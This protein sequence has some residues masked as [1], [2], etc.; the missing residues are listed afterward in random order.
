MIAII[1]KMYANQMTNSDDDERQDNNENEEENHRQILEK[2]DSEE[3]HIVDIDELS[4]FNSSCPWLDREGEIRPEQSENEIEEMITNM[5]ELPGEIEQNEEMCPDRFQSQSESDE[6]QE[7]E[8]LDVMKAENIPVIIER[9]RENSVNSR[10]D[11]HLEY[12]A[13]FSRRIRRS[14]HC[15]LTNDRTAN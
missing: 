9:M 6:E 5:S 4:D 15:L 14:L 2:E 10:V 3:V 12:I 8:K 13:A 1:S 11:E 7:E